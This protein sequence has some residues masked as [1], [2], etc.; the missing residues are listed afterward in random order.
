MDMHEHLDNAHRANDSKV[1]DYVAE[2]LD[3][4]YEDVHIGNLTF[5]PSEVLKAVDPIAWRETV[6]DELN[7]IG[8]DADACPFCDWAVSE[9]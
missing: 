4:V 8:E 5:L 1:Q 9:D 7:S 6:L 2:M 3:E